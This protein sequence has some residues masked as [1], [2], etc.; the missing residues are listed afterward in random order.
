MIEIKLNQKPLSVNE[1]WQ[2]RRFKTKKYKNYEKSVLLQLPKKKNI[3][4]RI[5]LDLHFGFSNKASDIDNPVKPILDILQKKYGF[6]DSN[7]WELEVIKTLTKKGEE[8]I[9]VNISDV[10]PI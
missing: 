2:G 4:E 6:N 5:R 7:V 3:P 8:F 1:A 10:L 9:K